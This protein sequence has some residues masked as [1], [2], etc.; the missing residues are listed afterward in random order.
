[1]Y[2]LSLEVDQAA[3]IE[4]DEELGR[5]YA[6][7]ASEWVDGVVDRAQRHFD[8][9]PKRESAFMHAMQRKGLT[10]GK[11]GKVCCKLLT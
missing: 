6:R 11:R 5:E 2:N 8:M 9:L 10:L 4:I 7:V 1:M 3:R